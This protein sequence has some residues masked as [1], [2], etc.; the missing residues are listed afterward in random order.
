APRPPVVNGTLWVVAGDPVTVTCG[1]DSDPAPIVTV[2]R[3][4]RAVAVA[5]YEAQVTLA[6]A[7]AQPED[8]GE[9]ECVAENQHGTSSTAFN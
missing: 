6:L 1:A 3:G 9:Y 7:A 8:A 5:V 4:Q 2:L